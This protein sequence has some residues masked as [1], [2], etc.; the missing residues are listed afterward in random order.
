MT[1]G[2][3]FVWLNGALVASVSVVFA[4]SALADNQNPPPSASTEEG[5]EE[6]GMVHFGLNSSKLNSQGKRSLDEVA[7]QASGNEELKVKVQ[8]YTDPTG[9]ADKN[10]RLSEKRAL[11]VENY[12]AKKGIDRDRI[13]TEGRGESPAADD[14]PASAER[15]AV[16]ATCQPTPAPAAEETPAPAPAPEATAPVE[17][18]PPPAPVEPL[19]SPAPMPSETGVT[20]R[21]YEAKPMSTIG[22]GITAGAG[23]MDFTQQRARSFTDAGVTWGVT[24]T[25]GTRLPVAL[26]L[27][28][29]GSSQ[30][31][32]LAGFS[33]D[34]YLLG[35]GVEGALRIQ[36]PKGWVRPYIFGGAGWRQLS[37]KRQN[38][39]GT[40]FLDY[41]NQGVVPF[42]AGVAIGQ[43]NGIMFDLHGTGRVTWD[44]DLLR[45]VLQNQGENLHTNTWDVTARIGGEF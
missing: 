42:G 14:K 18:T 9:N 26:D 16:V 23:V 27:S 11:S 37:I 45:N 1:A 15:V 41:D 30:N 20:A 24:G 4:T 43:V 33:T 2:R 19:P 13:S 39:F 36:Y 38:V 32:N 44:D 25:I 21:A 40:G 6:V 12:L 10:Q 28:Y 17:P 35:Q 22:I 8:A 34:A 29:I 7:T 3:K 31:I 5:C